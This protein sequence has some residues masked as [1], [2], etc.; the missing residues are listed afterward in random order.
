MYSGHKGYD[1]DVEMSEEQK[2]AVKVLANK[3]LIFN[4]NDAFEPSENSQIN[5]NTQ[6][7]ANKDL[8]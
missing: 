8:S 3:S 6:A 4:Q 5:A 7:T 2:E 1:E